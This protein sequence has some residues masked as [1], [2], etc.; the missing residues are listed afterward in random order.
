M[1]V[2]STV[3]RNL[4]IENRYLVPRYDKQLR[5]MGELRKLR[6]LGELN[7][8]FKVL[9]FVFKTSTCT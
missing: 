3:G 7:I 2:I 4:L 6:E 8:G 9:S 1:F 5:E